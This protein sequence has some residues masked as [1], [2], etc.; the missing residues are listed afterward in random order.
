MK[1]CPE[2]GE[3]SALAVEFERRGN[4]L[5]G[6]MI[7]YIG[8][9]DLKKGLFHDKPAELICSQPHVL[10]SARWNSSTNNR[11]NPDPSAAV[12]WFART[13]DV[14]PKP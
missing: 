9:G 2:Q 11:S 6:Q 5:A 10:L 14:S 7:S 13:R 12:R 1:C 8:G 3:T 4:S